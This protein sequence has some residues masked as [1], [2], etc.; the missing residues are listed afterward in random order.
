MEMSTR[1]SVARGPYN[2]NQLGGQEREKYPEK[3]FTEQE[4]TACWVIPLVSAGCGH[5]RAW[6]ASYFSQGEVVLSHWL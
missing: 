4:R 5:P 1:I 6:A 3:Y 2:K